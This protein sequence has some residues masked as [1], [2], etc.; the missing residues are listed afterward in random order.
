VEQAAEHVAAES[1]I[2]TWTEVCTEKNITPGLAPRIFEIEGNLLKIAYPEE[3][4]EPGNMPQIL[5]SI[6]GNVFGMGMLDELRLHDITFSDKL[7]ASFPGPSLGVGGVR[8]ILDVK[9]RPLV[10]TIV[11]PKVGL[12]TAAHAS[13]VYESM[14][15]GC[16]I[17]KDD[18]NLTSQGFNPF[19]ERLSQTLEAVDR[20]AEETGERKAYLPNVTGNIDEITK[21][22]EMVKD[23]GG[24]Y[25][26]IDV[27]TTGFSAVSHLRS[28]DLGLAIHAHRAMH[29]AITRNPRHGIS[30]L[31]F[32]KCL[33]LLGVDQLHIGAVV[34]KME[35]GQ[36]EVETIHQAI[37]DENFTGDK[38]NN[39][40]PQSWGSKRAVFS[41]ASGG[42]NPLHVPSLLEIFGS[43]VIMQFGGGIHGHPRG[44]RSGAMAVRQALELAIEGKPLTGDAEN[45]PE[46]AKAIELWGDL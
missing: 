23:M 17:V 19:E 46:L 5:S 45:H 2:G 8:K 11:K 36:G 9:K 29:G 16:D 35:G 43:D 3:L 22:A 26:M 37:N 15:G 13:V 39:A 31:V 20:A 4:F 1:S 10:G 34:G 41:V 6:A 32:A 12:P 27:L 42:L 18:E 7:T 40:I 21:R 33:R 30:M 14:A 44:S 24:T 38:A 25:A 28:L